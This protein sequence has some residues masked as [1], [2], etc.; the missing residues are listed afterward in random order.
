[1]YKFHKRQGQMLSNECYFYTDTIRDFKHLLTN[2]DLK[3][4]IINTWQYLTA[5]DIVEI[6]EAPHL[7]KTFMKSK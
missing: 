7:H 3:M 4:I 1:M 6:F 5:N 2:D